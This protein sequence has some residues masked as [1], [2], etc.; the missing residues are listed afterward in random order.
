MFF[1]IILLEMY[2][3]LITEMFIFIIFLQFLA[4]FCN[5]CICFSLIIVLSLKLLTNLTVISTYEHSIKIFLVPTEVCRDSMR[6]F[7]PFYIIEL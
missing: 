4:L 5:G 7:A 3:A 6:A 1:K 2:L